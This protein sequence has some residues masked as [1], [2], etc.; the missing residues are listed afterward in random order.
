MARAVSTY[1]V[2]GEVLLKINAGA[3]SF[4]AANPQ[5]EH[6]YHAFETVKLPE[7]TSMIPGMITQASDIVE[8]PELIDER[9]VRYTN[10]VGR[11]N[12]IAGAEC[13]FSSQATYCPEVQPTVM[14]AKF[15]AMA[16]GVRLATE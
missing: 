6:H 2:A 15:R 11:G 10:R 13:G 7:G 1:L 4:E 8:Q 12:M 16:E 9:L 14:W 3:Y 5:H